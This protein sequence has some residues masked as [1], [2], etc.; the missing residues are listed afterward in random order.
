[1]TSGTRRASVLRVLAMGV[2]IA[3]VPVPGLTFAQGLTGAIIGTV[4]DAQGG[5][6][7]GAIVRISSPALIGG[8]LTTKTD[9]RGQL[10]FPSVPPGSYAL[11]IVLQGFRPYRDASSSTPRAGRY[12]EPTPG[13]S[14]RV[15]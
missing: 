5:V 15:C 12:C 8:K 4:T 9:E 13:N 14:A 3:F 11:D 10:R 1:M 7:S 6:L 2:A